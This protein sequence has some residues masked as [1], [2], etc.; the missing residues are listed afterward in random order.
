MIQQTMKTT[1]K[2]VK[3]AKQCYSILDPK[4]AMR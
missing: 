1:K 3:H 2:P 4:T